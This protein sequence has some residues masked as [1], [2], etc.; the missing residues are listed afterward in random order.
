MIQRLA[1]ERSAS[2]IGVEDYTGG[3]DD[4]L[5]RIAE[6]P[7]QLA[8]NGFGNALN[9]KLGSTFVEVAC[10]DCLAQAIENGADRVSSSGAALAFQ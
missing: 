2:Q 6:R 9:G 4:F 1:R 10:A 8:L 5:E 7:S 3:V